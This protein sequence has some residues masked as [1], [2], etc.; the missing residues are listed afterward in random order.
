MTANAYAYI[1]ALY[2]AASPTYPTASAFYS[3]ALSGGGGGGINEVMY[4]FSVNAATNAVPV[5]QNITTVYTSGSPG[6]STNLS[7]GLVVFIPAVIGPKFKCTLQA[8]GA[9]SG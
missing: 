6:I 5:Y 7:G 1:D 3:A 8:I 9:S 4:D 2:A